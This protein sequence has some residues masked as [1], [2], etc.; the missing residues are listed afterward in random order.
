M[1]ALKSSYDLIIV[2]GG[3][4]GYTAAIY[5]I[6]AN[7]S[8]LLIAGEKAGGQLML[9]TDVED[10]PGFPKG[11]QGPELM[12]LFRD[13]ALNLGVDI[14][15]EDVTKADA[16]GKIKYAWADNKKYSAKVI[17]IATGASAKWLGLKNEQRLIGKG[18]T[19]C[20]VCDGAFFKNKPV[21]VVGGGDT[22]MREAIFMANLASSVT[23]I[24]RRDELKAQE[25]LQDRVKA[26]KK[27]KFLW[28][29][30]VQ[31]VLGNEKVTGI[32][33][34]NNKT[35]KTSELKIDGLFIAIGHKPN[36]GF[37]KGQVKLDDHN[38]IAL[39]EPGVSTKTSVPGV[40]AAGD[41]H[42]YRYMQAVTAASAGCKAA[43]DAHEYLEQS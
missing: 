16:K 18:V 24:H 23:I 14:I 26:N 37:L 27:I 28:N 29:T 10:Y 25:V 39:K 38:Y 40:F 43:L 17:I 41:V 3:P 19:S 32:K 21:A 4:A 22:A 2:G 5:G 20:A 36:T 6:R 30:E 31:D 33:L 7:M 34:I 9:T 15:N 35:K 1:A 12:K 8:T 13:Q 11:V 42:D